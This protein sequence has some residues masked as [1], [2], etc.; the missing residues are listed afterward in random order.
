MA[1]WRGLGVFWV[2][3][4]G[5]AGASGAALQ[6]MGP[7]KALVHDVD[8][9]QPQ[10]P[11]PEHAPPSAASAHVAL[12]SAPWPGPPIP[13]RKPGGVI[14]DP[15]PALLA[16]AP[17]FPG[18]KLP[19]IA[20]DGR[21]PMQVYARTVDPADTR[22]KLG[23]VLVGLGLSDAES[24]SAIDT[25]P[26]GVTLGISPYARDPDPLLADARAHGHEI[27]ITLPMESQ[28]Y[29]LNDSGPHA[30]LTGAEPF[31][32]ARNLEWVLSRVAG[33]A[34]VT[35]AS[36]G[37]RGE[38]LANAPSIFG[39]V[40]K[41]LASRGLLY[42]DPRPNTATTGAT[43]AVTT[44]VDDPPLR[45]AIDGRLAEL[46]Q[47]ARDGKPALGLA[48][49]LRPVTVEHIANWARGLDGRGIA[50][51]PVSALLPRSGSQ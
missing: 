7:P 13:P 16:A 17:D 49:P 48:G 26:P 20:A 2:A 35:G 50:L 25:L 29:P 18:A 30:L 15:E 42:V 3:A 36:D 11:S 8:T 10:P 46:E 45:A 24:R 47:R 4:L 6:V 19:R 14:A 39:P 32:N 12:A 5:I 21:Q 28:G 22:P 9:P 44:V 41:E 40:L 33:A 23:I 27:L 43:V 1:R 51:V 37:L 34:G 31:D 38:R